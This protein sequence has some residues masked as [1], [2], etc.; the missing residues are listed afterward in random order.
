MTTALRYEGVGHTFLDGNGHSLIALENISFDVTEGEFVSLVG[1]S[2]C[3][4]STLLRITAGLLECT[5]GQVKCRGSV[6]AEPRSGIGLMLQTPT[7]F[8]WR[9]AVRNV[10]LP[11]EIA[12]ERPSSYTTRVD[13]VLELVGLEKFANMYPSELSGGMQQRVALSRLLVADPDVMLMD[14]PFGALDEF[15]REYLNIE[16]ARISEHAHKTTVFVTHNIE[17]AVFLSDRVL[18]MGNEP[19]RIL[20]TVEVDVP[21]PRSPL[22]RRHTAFHETVQHIRRT[23]GLG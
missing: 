19:G 16:L 5:V 11:L 23:V 18:V 12:G 14:E 21:R 17:E 6:V 15:T 7:L 9:T 1:P 13:Q 8:P 3:G 4:K 2:G 10:S 22:S 20:E